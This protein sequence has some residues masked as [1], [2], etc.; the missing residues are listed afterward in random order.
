M[1]NKEGVNIAGRLEYQ[2]EK[3]VYDIYAANTNVGLSN[4]AVYHLQEEI[5]KYLSE[6]GY[7]EFDYG[8][9][10]PSD[11]H[12]DDIYIAKSYSGGAPIGYNG[13]WQYCKTLIKK[14]ISSVYT[15]CIHRSQLY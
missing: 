10:P 1:K 15:F 11:N 4:G 2:C 6:H 13:Q 7:S 14:Y 8:M 9:I 3:N 12:M 5:L